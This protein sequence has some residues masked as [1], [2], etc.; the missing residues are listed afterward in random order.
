[1]SIKK[2]RKTYFNYKINS[3]PLSDYLSSPSI[4]SYESIEKKYYTIEKK[5]ISNDIQEYLSLI[6]I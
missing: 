5:R 2:S 4:K 3:S 1:M 6:H